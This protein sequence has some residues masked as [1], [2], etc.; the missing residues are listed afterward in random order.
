MLS[1]Y[2]DGQGYRKFDVGPA[3]ANKSLKVH[4]L[5]A[6]LFIPNFERKPQ[7]NHI[8]GDKDNNAWTNLEWVTSQENIDHAWK[9]GL[10]KRSNS[11]S[12]L[13]GVTWHPSVGKW[14]AR[15]HCLGKRHDLGRYDTIQEASDAIKNFKSP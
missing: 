12:G 2:D 9:T 1:P 4:R 6:E 3:A 8:D 13:R 15:A 10:S 7:V 5:V 11:S 14:Q